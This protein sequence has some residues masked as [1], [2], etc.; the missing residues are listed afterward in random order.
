MKKKIGN[1]FDGDNSDT[2]VVPESDVIIY[3][4]A[5]RQ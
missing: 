3:E 1:G 5:K 4:G 2:R